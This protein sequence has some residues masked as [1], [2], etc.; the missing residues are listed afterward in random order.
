MSGGAW[1]AT[2]EARFAISTF[3]W[4]RALLVW[5]AEVFHTW[6]PSWLYRESLMSL[7]MLLPA[8]DVSTLA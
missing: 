2:L 6:T 3:S 8:R 7:P 4:P 1:T 5:W